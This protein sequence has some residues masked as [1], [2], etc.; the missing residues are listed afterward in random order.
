MLRNRMGR[1]SVERHEKGREV[2]LMQDKE[3]SWFV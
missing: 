1:W 2:V 3:Y